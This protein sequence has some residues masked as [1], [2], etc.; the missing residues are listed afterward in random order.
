MCLPL[1]MAGMLGG[2]VPGAAQE[3]WLRVQ[4]AHEELALLRRHGVSAVQPVVA[5]Q[6]R[7]ARRGAFKAAAHKG[8]H[9]MCMG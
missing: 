7:V 4:L 9:I 1:V 6:A 5:G 8:G 3:G 2:W